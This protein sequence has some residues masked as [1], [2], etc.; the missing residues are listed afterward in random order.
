MASVPGIA[1]QN[2]GGTTLHSFTGMFSCLHDQVG[3]STV[4]RM[5]NSSKV[6]RLWKA[7]EEK[8]KVCSKM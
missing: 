5:W 8:R 6:F 1:A 2:I 3:E 4:H 7:L